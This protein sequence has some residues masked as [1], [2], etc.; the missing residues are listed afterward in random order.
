LECWNVEMYDG[1]MTANG[2]MFV[3]EGVSKSVLGLTK[4]HAWKMYPAL[5]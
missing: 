4:Y 5:I 1:G 3:M 2:M